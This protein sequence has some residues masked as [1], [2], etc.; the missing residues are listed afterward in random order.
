[1]LV[2]KFVVLCV[3]LCNSVG[4]FLNDSVIGAECSSRETVG[5]FL[6]SS[7]CDLP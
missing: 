2:S 3:V 7:L 4:V 6:E 5:R 1:M